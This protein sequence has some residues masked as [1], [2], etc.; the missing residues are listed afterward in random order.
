[1]VLCDVAAAGQ[2]LADKA[3]QLRPGKVGCWPVSTAAVGLGFVPFVAPAA[4]FAVLMVCRLPH[5]T[6]L[7]LCQTVTTL[8]SKSSRRPSFSMPCCC[9]ASAWDLLL[10]LLIPGHL[11]HDTRCCCTYGTCIL[12]ACRLPQTTEWKLFR[13]AATLCS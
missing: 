2:A 1:M 12:T 10:H 9:A 11:T 5:T 6:K 13:T 7:G 4:A 8:C 3:E